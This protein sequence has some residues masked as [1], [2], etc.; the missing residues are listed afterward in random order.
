MGLV[1]PFFLLDVV[2]VID[3]F[4]LIKTPISEHGVQVEI[5]ARYGGRCITSLPLGWIGVL[6]GHIQ[7]SFHMSLAR[8]FRL[9]RACT[10]YV[11]IDRSSLSIG[12]IN[13]MY[14]YFLIFMSA[15]HGFA[16]VS[17]VLATFGDPDNS[18]I[19]P[20]ASLSPVERDVASLYFVM[21]A[22]LTISYGA[23]RPR[24]REHTLRRGGE[25]VSAAHRSRGQYDK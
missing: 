7:V 21:A 10:A 12:T 3:N 14:P 17:Y 11:M 25:C 2:Q 22:I 16:C 5:L 24:M 15:L 18:Y 9:H 1:L 6:L 20:F 23:G 4:V 19:T 8:L 13:R